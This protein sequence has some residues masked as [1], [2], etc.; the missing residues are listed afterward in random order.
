MDIG[1]GEMFEAAASLQSINQDMVKSISYL[2]GERK[3][4]ADKIAA[5]EEEHQAVENDITQLRQKLDQLAQELEK[6]RQ[7]LQTQDSKLM[8]AEIGYGKVV[9][10][11]RMLLMSVKNDR[12]FNQ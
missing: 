7:Q 2:R 4:L 3:K 11:M 10:T 1:H 9:D 8:E 12:K 5:Q 6:N